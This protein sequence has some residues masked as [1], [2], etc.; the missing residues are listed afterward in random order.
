M[1]LFNRRYQHHFCYL[2]TWWHT[3]YEVGTTLRGD[4]RVSVW[5]HVIASWL[6]ESGGG[7]E[8][9]W[10]VGRQGVCDRSRCFL[11]F[12]NCKLFLSKNRTCIQ[13]F[14]CC[15]SG[16]TVT[17]CP[18]STYRALNRDT[19]IGTCLCV[20]VCVSTICDESLVLKTDKP[21]RLDYNSEVCACMFLCVLCLVTASE[22]SS[23]FI[24][25]KTSVEGYWQATK[26]PFHFGV[27]KC[28]QLYLRML[29]VSAERTAMYTVPIT[30]SSFKYMV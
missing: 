6:S 5:R 26:S 16:P 25:Y 7:T 28:K 15:C 20:C 22:V 1:Y 11:L 4:S 8:F 13:S 3:H 30:D 24:V 10:A 21:F 17:C 19:W 2:E 12:D 14:C 18:I 29:C 23:I 9:C 27:G